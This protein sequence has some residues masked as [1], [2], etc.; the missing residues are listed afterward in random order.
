ML[1]IIKFFFRFLKKKPWLFPPIF[2]IIIAI[3]IA[4]LSN[5]PVTAPFL[6]T[7]F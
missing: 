3:L 4:S 7:L 5:N 2:L 6:Y 1:D